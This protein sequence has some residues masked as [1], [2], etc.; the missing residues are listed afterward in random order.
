MS[1]I[2]VN[3]PFTVPIEIDTEDLQ[4]DGDFVEVVRCRD[5]RYFCYRVEHKI[6]FCKK[7]ARREYE[8][9]KQLEVVPEGFCSKGERISK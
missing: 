5:C 1:V 9:H 8:L 2:K 7:W 4:L 3:V 6:Y